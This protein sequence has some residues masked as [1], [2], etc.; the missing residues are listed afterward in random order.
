MMVS[1]LLGGNEPRVVRFNFGVTVVFAIN[2]VV[3]EFGDLW[4]CDGGGHT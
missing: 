4:R 1:F 3:L 2:R